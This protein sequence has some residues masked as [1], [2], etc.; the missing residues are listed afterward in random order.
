[1]CTVTFI[2]LKDKYVLTSNRDEKAH[3]PTLSP[4]LYKFDNAKFI[5]PKDE[6]NGG[7][8]IVA[9]VDGT[10]IVLLNGAYVRHT[11]KDSYRSSR[12]LILL[13]IIKAKVPLS[14]FIDM[15]LDNIEPFT[16]IIFHN[17]ILTEVKWDG[18]DKHILDKSIHKPHIW[19]S[20]TLYSRRQHTTRKKWFDD[21]CRTKATLTTEMIVSFHTT[22]QTANTEYGLIIN[23]ID[24]TKT[25]SITQVLLDKNHVEM[26]YI[27]RIKN[28]I[29]E[30]IKF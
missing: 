30:K 24:E 26:T 23:R 4:K 29:P 12:G 15:E 9:R 28:Q 22:T 14:Y 13:D 8:W 11:K 1:M 3:R 25:V 7:T 18:V 21:F 2:P 10:C 20:A 16:L 17:N 6:K 19:S 27:D 5:F